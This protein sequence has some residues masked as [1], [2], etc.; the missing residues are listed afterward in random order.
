VHRLAARHLDVRWMWRESHGD[1]LVTLCVEV[2]S[3]LLTPFRLRTL[4][5]PRNYIHVS[6]IMIGSCQCMTISSGI[7]SPLET[8]TAISTQTSSP[9]TTRKQRQK[10]RSGHHREGS[11]GLSARSTNAALLV[12]HHYC[13]RQ[14]LP[15]MA[16]SLM[17]T[18]I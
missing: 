13:H 12:L 5:R 14:H 9:S 11:Q 18:D 17:W 15:L 2:H 10:E 7:L 3:S 1:E 6:T 16:S 8:N 4:A